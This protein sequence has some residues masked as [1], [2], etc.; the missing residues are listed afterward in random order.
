ML[1]IPAIDL[2][3]GKCVRLKQGRMD[4]ADVFGDDPVAM[5]KRW[6][7]AGA[8]RLHLVDLDGAF[9]G[10][11]R[12]LE[13]VAQIIRACPDLELEL[14]GG[15]R[16]MQ[17]LETY[18]EIGLHMGIIGTA[19]IKDPAFVVEACA[20]FPNRIIVGLDAK[21][22]MVATQGWDDVSEVSAIDC[23]K[24]FAD[25]GVS[26]IIFTDIARDGM[27][28]GVNVDATAELAE[29]GGIPVIA[30]GGVH[31]LDDIRACKAQSHRGICGVITGRAIYEGTLDLAEAQA[32]AFAP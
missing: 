12:H 2:K 29:A 27:R 3:D 18:L 1:V 5:A 16:T 9:A 24:R 11:P 21:D 8:H 20:R 6:Q 31:T 22:G 4:D 7:D 30:S 32:L 10:E 15:I 14:G 19:A 25:A 28:A 17:T 26:A 23:A 13:V